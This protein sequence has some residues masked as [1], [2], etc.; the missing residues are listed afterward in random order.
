MECGGGIQE[1]VNPDSSSI[2]S[3][4]DTTGE[5]RSLPDAGEIEA[6]PAQT[7]EKPANFANAS[8]FPNRF[9]NRREEDMVATV[10]LAV[11]ALA[12]VAFLV[13]MLGLLQIHGPR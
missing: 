2:T 12:I 11:A 6:R 5:E 3:S 7:S 9:P 4:S 13:S 1:E 8:P 10:V